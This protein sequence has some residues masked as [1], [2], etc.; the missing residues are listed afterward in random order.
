MKKHNIIFLGNNERTL[1]SLLNCNINV[2]AAIYELNRTV[3][4]TGRYDGAVKSQ[5]GKVIGIPKDDK[6]ALMEVLKDFERPALFVVSFFAILPRQALEFPEIGCLNIHPSLLPY[7][8]GPYPINWALINDEKQIG[9]S[10]MGLD[11]GVDTGGIYRQFPIDITD[12][13]DALTL[14]NK[15]NDIVDKNICEVIYEVLEGSLV[16]KPQNGSGSYYPRLTFN[17]RFVNFNKMTARD[18]HNLTRSQIE[19]G[20]IITTFNF[21]RLEFFRSRIVDEHSQEEYPGM[22]I[23]INKDE[24]CGYSISVQ[25]IRGKLELFSEEETIKSLNIGYK[26][27]T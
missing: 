5:G 16:A 8:K 26:L 2:I 14:L 3:N 17:V 12:E 6:Y 27:G 22:I 13:D 23:K 1:K 11:M 18:I 20:G 24:F 21:K 7:Y 19:Y 4:Y 25:C 10:F 15:A 9:V